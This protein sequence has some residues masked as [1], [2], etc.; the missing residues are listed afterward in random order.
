MGKLILITGGARSGK[1]IFAEKKAGELGEKILY[2]ATSIPFD[3]EMKDR[4]RKH[5]EQRP[6]YWDT[7]E[8]YKELD[9][10]IKRTY[11][12]HQGILLDCITVMTSNI[13]FEGEITDWDT[14]TMD[15]INMLEMHVKSE[16]DKLISITT[17]MD[18]PVIAVTNELSMGI[19][20]ENR[21]ARIF[22]DIAGR[23]NQ[24]LAAVA[25]EVYLVVS[26]IPIKIK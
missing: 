18:V 7:L 12:G 3:D 5:K 2:I 4:I 11:N 24:Q 23:A 1:S 26:G 19:V 16:I 9:T 25:E 8:T 21:L 22:R 10:E 20:P 15:E 14:C 6:A 13:L 17:H